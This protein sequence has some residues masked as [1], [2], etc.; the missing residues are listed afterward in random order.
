MDE[1]TA[2]KVY[3]RALALDPVLGDLGDAVDAIE[4]E[5]ERRRFKRA[6]GDLMGTVYAEVIHPLERQFPGLIPEKERRSP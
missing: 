1:E 3:D 6:I 4:D 5:V 2:R